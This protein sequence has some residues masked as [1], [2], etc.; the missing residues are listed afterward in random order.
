[1]RETGTENGSGRE[2]EIHRAIFGTPVR[3]ALPDATTPARC[4]LRISRPVCRLR[5]FFP[6]PLFPFSGPVIRFP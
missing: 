1:M 6:F 5:L 2:A 3:A 4:P